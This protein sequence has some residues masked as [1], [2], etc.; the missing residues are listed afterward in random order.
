MSSALLPFATAVFLWT[1]AG[2]P[3]ERVSAGAASP[4]PVATQAAQD[5][6]TIHTSGAN[7]PA[8][9]AI[10]SSESCF[11]AA[12]QACQPATL[13]VM[14]RGVDTSATTTFSVVAAS[15]SCY[16]AGTAVSVLVPR[17]SRTTS[18]SC[19]SVAAQD[20]GLVVQGCDQ[21]G[22]ISLPASSP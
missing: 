10:A 17:G 19:D 21:Y 5:C 14:T 22:D 8:D 11:L 7:P 18:F 15:G 9:P 13:T 3:E 4:T 6:G 1:L 20:S 12:F 2:A 16:V